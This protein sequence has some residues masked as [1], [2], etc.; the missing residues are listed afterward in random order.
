MALLSFS[1]R[2]RIPL[3]GSG[4]GGLQGRLTGHAGR[5]AWP[6]T[7]GSHSRIRRAGMR[8]MSGGEGRP[9]SL[10]DCARCLVSSVS[11]R[12]GARLFRGRAA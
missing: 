8:R 4:R 7:P 9:S 3:T 1:R 12:G 11:G 5:G 2:S 6:E 10:L